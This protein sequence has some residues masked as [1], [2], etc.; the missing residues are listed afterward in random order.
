M[1]ENMGFFGK[2]RDNNR[3][4]RKK[5]EILDKQYK[6]D[7]Q[8]KI[9]YKP[10]NVKKGFSQDE[11]KTLSIPGEI[12]YQFMALLDQSEYKYAYEM[13]ADQMQPSIDRMSDLE[14]QMFALRIKQLKQKGK[15]NS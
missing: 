2:K 3:P 9:T 14:K 11:R 13:L 5:S 10:L 8:P 7:P 6:E 1:A 4:V 12:Y 15:S